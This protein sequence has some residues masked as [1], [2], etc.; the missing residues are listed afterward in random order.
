MKASSLTCTLTRK[1][2][3]PCLLLSA[4]TVSMAATSEFHK[5]WSWL[6]LTTGAV[7]STESKKYSD[8]NLAIVFYA[9]S[10]CQPL[11]MYS[12]PI[13]DGTE[14]TEGPIDSAY[15]I[16]V[17][18][19]PV[20]DVPEG[21]VDGAVVE[22][23]GE[24]DWYHYVMSIPSKLLR[25]LVQ[26]YTIRVKEAGSDV[27]DRFSLHGSARAIRSAY[28]ICERTAGRSSDPD[29]QYFSAGNNATGST[30]ETEDSDRGYFES[31]QR[32]EKRP[33]N[34]DDDRDFFD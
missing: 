10:N 23:E 24:S 11:L 5:D 14:V 22:A 26:G 3:L 17:D 8:V 25:E 6:D 21:S 28:Q 1:V 2:F 12:Q 18:K 15:Q 7:A 16:R 33:G 9:N 32:P 20:W 19:K 4:G 34:K 29:L 13:P 27:T 31:E 30:Q